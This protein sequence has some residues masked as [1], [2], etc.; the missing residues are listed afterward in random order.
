M[1]NKKAILITLGVILLICLSIVCRC[2][3]QKGLTI[4][5][6]AANHPGPE[7]QSV[8]QFTIGTVA[9]PVG[10][11]GNFVIQYQPISCLFVPQLAFDTRNIQ[12]LNYTNE[13][14]LL[15][16]QSRFQSQSSGKYGTGL[17]LISDSQDSFAVVLCD[18]DPD[19]EEIINTYFKV[20]YDIDLNNEYR[21]TYAY[22]ETY[23]SNLNYYTLEDVYTPI[24]LTANLIT[25]NWN[26][27]ENPYPYDNMYVNYDL[28]K[29]CLIQL[30]NQANAD[31]FW[32]SYFLYNITIEEYLSQILALND[33]NDLRTELGFL[34]IGMAN[35]TYIYYFNISQYEDNSGYNDGYRNGRQDGI[36]AV[37]RNPNLFD[38]YTSEQYNAALEGNI[39][40]DWLTSIFTT[41][42]NFL[43][44]ELLPNIKLIYIISIPLIFGFVRMLIR[45]FK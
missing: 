24:I 32:Q 6:Y 38:L 36:T 43:Q 42:T 12:Y 44:L 35:Q 9:D 37:T 28:Y 7:I 18:Y 5:V 20:V 29:H 39:S 2:S 8:E 41:A 27:S 16:N 30:F 33:I 10:D 17:R 45:W 13:W 1:K 31:Y 11:G 25:T 3:T 40:F 15:F 34:A 21:V 4:K 22:M 19:N 14:I 23:M 26:E